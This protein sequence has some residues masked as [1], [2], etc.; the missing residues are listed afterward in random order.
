MEPIMYIGIAIAV[1]AGIGGFFY[2]L[3]SDKTTTDK[4]D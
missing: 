4:K 3:R 2:A 1:A